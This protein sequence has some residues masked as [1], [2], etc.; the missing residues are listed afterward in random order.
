M[1][2]GFTGTRDGMTAE[3]AAVFE[4]FVPL[5]TEFHHGSCKGADIEA[6]MIVR[7]IFMVHVPIICH[8]GPDGDPCQYESGVDDLRHAP[9]T[10]FARNRD[11][12]NQTDML[13]ACPCDMSEQSR[14]GTWYTVNYAK[15]VGKPVTIIWPDGSFGGAKLPSVRREHC[16]T[17]GQSGESLCPHGYSDLA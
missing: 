8:P 7:K 11:I 17:C 3:Q 12:V 10:H 6:A 13:I 14:G 15:K 1:R 9:K 4:G 2:V 5:P 16:P